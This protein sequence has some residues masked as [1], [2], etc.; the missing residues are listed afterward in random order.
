VRCLHLYWRRV[1]RNTLP[2]TAGHLHP[3]VGPPLIIIIE[4]LS[5][6]IG[7]FTFEA[8]GRDGRIAEYRH[9]HILVLGAIPFRVFVKR[10]RPALSLTFPSASVTTILSASSGATKSAVFV[11]LPLKPLLFQGRDS[12]FRASARRRSDSKLR[13]Q[14]VPALPPI[15]SS[16]FEKAILMPRSEWDAVEN[17]RAAGL[18]C[19]EIVIVAPLERVVSKQ[20]RSAGFSILAEG[21]TVGGRLTFCGLPCK[22]NTAFRG[23]SR[24]KWGFPF[25]QKWPAVGTSGQ[26]PLH[27]PGAGN[28]GEKFRRHRPL[29]LLTAH[30]DN[31][32]PVL[33]L[34]PCSHITS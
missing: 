29:L 12:F 5:H 31:R 6:R 23:H 1:T 17:S 26:Q 13:L 7:A 19:N 18:G 11:F 34:A 4:R 21:E 15:T 32:R 20:N 27:L 2:F 24:I 10:K 28:S 9:L 3:R 30:P 33:N 22:I 14:V 25:R 8:S 16:E